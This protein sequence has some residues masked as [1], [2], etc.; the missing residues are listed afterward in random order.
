MGGIRKTNINQQDSDGMSSL[1]QAALQCSVPVMRVLLDQG[2]TVDLKDARGMRPLHYAAWQGKAE[3][4]GLLLEYN[5]SVNEASNSGDTPLHLAAQHGHPLV[6]EKLLRFHANLMVRNG[7][8]KTPLDVACEFGRLKVV[9]LLLSTPRCRQLLGESR[10]DLLDNERTT[11]LHL[12]ARNG[13]TD[14]I[15]CLLAAGVDINRSTLRGTALHEAAMHGKLEVVRLLIQSG[16]DVNKPN[17][18]EQTAL[19]LVRSFTSSK[20][21][22]DLKVLLKEMLQAVPARAIRDHYDHCDADCLPLQEGDLVTV[23]ILCFAS[24]YFVLPM[25]PL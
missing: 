20:A 1:H 3:P 4:V 2:A 15:R 9:E 21:A 13:H 16:V 11:C 22:R 5:S 17:S 23:R 14:V 18:S 6:V 8:H 24:F 19:D 12:A 25:L 7:D 10:Q